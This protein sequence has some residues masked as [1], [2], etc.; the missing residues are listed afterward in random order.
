[1]YSAEFG[2]ADVH[3]HTRLSD[4]LASPKQVLDHVARH[5]R[6]NVIAIT[7]HDRLDGS[8]WAAEQRGWYPFDIIPGM[9]VS[10]ADGHVLALWVSSPIPAGLSIQETTRAIHEQGGVAILAHPGEMLIHRDSTLRYLRQPEVLFTLNVDAV[11]VYNAGTMTPGNNL[12]ARRICNRIAVPV[13]GSSD[14]HTLSAIGLGKTRFPG[15]TAD[16]FRAAL[17]HRETAAE[18]ERWPITDYLKLSI[19]SIPR[20]RNKSTIRS[21]PLMPPTPMG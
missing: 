5:T 14:A 17:H 13:T 10:A 19:S 21:L 7:D 8:L 9:E 15:R 4:G 11:E 18:G 20:R 3:M 2:T 16:E 1:M 6:L 12:I